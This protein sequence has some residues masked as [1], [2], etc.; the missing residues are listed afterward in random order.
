[1][2]LRELLGR[3][4]IRISAQFGLV[5]GW[6][7]TCYC[8]LQLDNGL[9]IDLPSMVESLEDGVGTQDALPAGSTELTHR[10]PFVLNQPIVGI[11][12]YEYEDDILTAALL[13]L[14]NGYLLTE[15]NMAPSGTGAAALWHLASLADVEAQFGPDYRRLA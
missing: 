8:Y 12:S 4:I 11:I 14:A 13:E 5:D 3:S 1:M 10:V 2:L 15:V 9:V 7:D 6:L